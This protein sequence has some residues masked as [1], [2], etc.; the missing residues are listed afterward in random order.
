MNPMDQAW[1]MALHRRQAGGARAQR[2]GEHLLRRVALAFILAFLL[3][4]PVL[5]WAHVEAPSTFS[6]NPSSHHDV[7]LV[8]PWGLPTEALPSTLLETSLLLMLC[9]LLALALAWR[10]RRWRR[11]TAL[12]LA[13]GLGVFTFGVAVHAVH[14]LA[15]PE[16][17]A[18]CPVYFASQHIPCAPVD[19]CD[20]CV[21]GVVVA[22]P[23]ESCI[24][25][26]VLPSYLHLAQPR[27]PPPFPI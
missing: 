12:A 22:G 17:A 26:P 11:A 25:G 16:K 23:V 5:S 1:R 6:L 24:V 3:G 27:A 13:L 9:G 15:E 7:P 10:R 2:C 4:G 18:E 19:T 8:D 14:H 21:P 20:G